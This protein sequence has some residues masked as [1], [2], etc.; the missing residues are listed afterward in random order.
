[1]LPLA[2]L[3]YFRLR[4]QPVLRL[5]LWR[6]PRSSYLSSRR[7]NSTT[8]PARARILSVG[9]RVCVLL[10]YFV[11]DIEDLCY[12]CTFLHL[13]PS[14]GVYDCLTNSHLPSSPWTH[15]SSVS[16]IPA[17]LCSCTA[18]SHVQ[19]TVNYICPLYIW[20]NHAGDA[21]L[22]QPYEGLA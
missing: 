11:A 3:H 5:H 12:S 1:M 22:F 8:H 16:V 10:L 4:T 20:N 7:V 2:H 9:G 15:F 13:C 18:G 19:C 6:E 17:C 21:A 14:C